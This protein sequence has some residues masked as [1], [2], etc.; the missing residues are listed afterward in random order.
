MHR[1]EDRVRAGMRPGRRQVDQVEG[2]GAQAVAQHH[3]LLRLGLG[4]RS[5]MDRVKRR[6][7]GCLPFTAD[8][9]MS[10][11]VSYHTLRAQPDRI[12][13]SWSRFLRLPAGGGRGRPAGGSCCGWRISIRHVAARSSPMLSCGT[14][15][16]LASTGTARCGCNRTICP[17][18][19]RC[20]TACRRGAVISVL[21]HPVRCDAGARRL[22]LRTACAGRRADVSRHLPPPLSR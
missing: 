7:A 20:W 6:H 21:L 15:R 3:K 4:G 5:P 2:I 10:R 16:G 1:G 17:S 22:G 13:A 19:R 9:V 8:T 12:S 14:L 11:H 18:I